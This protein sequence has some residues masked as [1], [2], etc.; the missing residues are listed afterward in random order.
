MIINKNEQKEIRFDDVDHLF[1]D[2]IT[3]HQD[4]ADVKTETRK[5]IRSYKPRLLIVYRDEKQKW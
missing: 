4:Q 5:P 2:A 1:D 3:L